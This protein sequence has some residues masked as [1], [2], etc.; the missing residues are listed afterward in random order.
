MCWFS[1]DWCVLLT[2]RMVSKLNVSPFHNVNSPLDAPVTSLR[3]SG[4]HCTQDTINCRLKHFNECYK[5]LTLTLVL[6]PKPPN[7]YKNIS[8]TSINRHFQN[9]HA[10]VNKWAS[11]RTKLHMLALL[12]QTQNIGHL[13]LL[14]DWRIN[15][16]VTLLTGLSMR[17]WGG[18]ICN[19]PRIYLH[20]KHHSFKICRITVEDICYYLICIQLHSLS[21]Y[22]AHRVE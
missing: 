15:F 10:L 16:V 1:V 18:N 17:Q 13:I 19:M 9:D 21:D 12:T 4:V 14:V 11:S 6:A 22:I 3:P 7:L 2:W 20:I 8:I 5:S